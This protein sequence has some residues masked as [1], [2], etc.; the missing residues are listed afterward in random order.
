MHQIHHSFFSVIKADFYSFLMD[1]TVVRH[2]HFQLNPS[3]ISDHKS[4]SH[5][6]KKNE[7]MTGEMGGGEG[8]ALS[9]PS[10]AISWSSHYRAISTDLPVHSDN[11]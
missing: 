4:I 10:S 6:I 8:E 2:V 1:F 11:Q 7:S 3:S 9:C 5:A